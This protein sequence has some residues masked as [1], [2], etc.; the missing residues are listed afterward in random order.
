MRREHRLVE[1]EWDYGKANHSN[2]AL[3]PFSQENDALLDQHLAKQ[4]RRLGAKG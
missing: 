1:H 3:R 4:A 2:G